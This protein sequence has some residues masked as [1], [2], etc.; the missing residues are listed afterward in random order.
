MESTLIIPELLSHVIMDTDWIHL[1]H[2]HHLLDV[3]VV[4]EAK[5]LGA[6]TL[7]D[8]SEVLQFKF[9]AN[10]IHFISLNALSIIRNSN[11][12]FEMMQFYNYC[13]NDI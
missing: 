13:L 8:V 1:V 9:I 12:M 3:V 5:E 7:Q 4:E 2:L 6:T 10:I 11:K